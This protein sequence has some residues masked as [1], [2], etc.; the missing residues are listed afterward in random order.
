MHAALDATPLTVAT[1]GIG[2]YTSELARA[3][4]EAFPGDVYSLVSDQPF[5]MPPDCPPN[6]KRGGAPRHSLERFWWSFGL[7][8]ELSRSHADIFHGTGFS[9]PYFARIPRVMTLHDLSPWMD[10]RWGSGAER[11]RKRVPLLLG[12]GIATMV[13]TVSEAVRREA[14]ER[15]RLNPA[16]VAAVPNAAAAM[17][18]PVPSAPAKP[19]FLYLGTLEPRKNLGRLI[20]AWNLVRE[21]K[22]VDLILAGCRRGDFPEIAERPGLR[23]LGAVADERLPELYSGALAFVYPSHYEG[24]GL[25]VLEAMQCGALALVSNDPAIREVT[26]DA[27]VHLDPGSTRAWAEAME[28]AASRP[29][30][31]ARMR[32]RALRRAREFSWAKTAART[33][34]VYEQALC[35]V[36]YS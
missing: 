9:V 10:P 12:L 13:V 20:E 18:R 5:E 14:I 7:G 3:L 26:G 19:Y 23:I 1:G 22:D 6:V 32:E 29:E 28:A 25:P 34:E 17:F 2:R 8:R 35:L 24:F 33:R 15:F 16:R 27:A 30:W 4:G 31:T 36:S 21:K 11:I